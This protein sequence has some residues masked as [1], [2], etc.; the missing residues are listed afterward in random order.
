MSCD[1]TLGSLLFS[2]PVRPWTREKQAQQTA[3][4]GLG[5]LSLLRS[6]DASSASIP[7][8]MQPPVSR[9]TC[10]ADLR[11]AQS[12]LGHTPNVNVTLQ[13]QIPDLSTV[14][15]FIS[16]S[17]TDTSTAHLPALALSRLS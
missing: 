7:S 12:G 2:L 6:W 11:D 16:D 13:M 10:I 17:T 15:I 8:G 14:T 3:T 1:L 4:K 9:D 5:L